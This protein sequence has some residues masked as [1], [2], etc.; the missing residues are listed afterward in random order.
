M[1]ERPL[2]SFMKCL[3]SLKESRFI[4]F[5][6][7]LFVTIFLFLSH[8]VYGL[9]PHE[10]LIIA[11]KNSPESLKLARFYQEKRYIPKEN[12]IRLDC[13]SS[14]EISREDFD[15]RIARPLKLALS[16]P[17]WAVSIKCLLLT[18]GMP[19]RIKNTKLNKKKALELQTLKERIK[20]IKDLIGDKNIPKK[21]Q[22]T[23]KKEL[24][25]LKNRLNKLESLNTGASVDSELTLI[26]IYGDYELEGWIKNPLFLWDK[27]RFNSKIPRDKVLMVSRIDGPDIKVS[28]RIIEDALFAE[29]RGLKGLVCI[30]SRYKKIPQKGPIDYYHLY[31]KWLKNTASFLKEEGFFVKIDETPELFGPG[32]CND[33]AIYCG[34]Y[35]LSHFV[36]GF[37]WVRGAIGYHVAS[38]EC[39]SLHGK[40]D[41]WCRRLLMDGVSVTLGP[42][43]EPYLQA[44]PPPQLF[45]G[46]LI[47]K[48]LSIGEAYILSCPF[49]SWQMVLIGDPLYRPFGLKRL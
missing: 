12:I 15:K 21:K 39:V 34:W 22:L 30:D 28:K 24:K 37:T 36:D 6:S 45:F 38:G 42:V 7:F 17:G 20:A 11:N 13:P 10:I 1:Q 35:S 33:T 46:L 29:K 4:T 47:E 8:N 2:K 3:A 26:K 18:Y 31:D 27:D 32:S 9:K 5:L 40:N 14:E 23:L 19:F 44:F 41:E 49:L 48:G 16:M 43:A 25:G